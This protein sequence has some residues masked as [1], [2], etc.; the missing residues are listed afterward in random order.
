MIY[1]TR[2]ASRLEEPVTILC[3][4]Q[5]EAVETDHGPGKRCTRCWL[6]WSDNWYSPLPV[7]AVSDE[8]LK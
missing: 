4:H 5:F 3:K 6:F 1:Q 7:L 8:A 2:A